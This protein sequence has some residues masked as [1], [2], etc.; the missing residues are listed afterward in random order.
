MP[1]ALSMGGFTAAA[2]LIA[3]PA[4]AAPMDVVA[5]RTAQA[6]AIDGVMDPAWDKAKP[7][8]VAV[9]ENTY[10]PS[11]GYKGITATDVELRALTDGADLFLLV[12]YRD[13]THSI[14]RFPWVKQADGG[15]RK[16]VDKDSTGHENTHY[17]DKVAIFWNI[18][19]KGFAKKGCEQSCHT[20]DN[21]K[22]DG[23]EDSSAGRHFTAGPGERLDMWHMKTAR[24]NP[25][26]QSDDQHVDWSRNDSK[27]WGRKTD[28]KTGGGYVN[29]ETPAKTAPA[30]MPATAGGD[31]YWILDHAKAPL[32][33]SRFKA[34][35]VVGGIVTAPF[36]GPRADVTAKG[37]W[38][39]GVWT[40]EFRRKLVT[41]S[42]TAAEEDVQFSDL[43]K[44][45]PFGVA[46]FDNTQINHLFHKKPLVL[47]FE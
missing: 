12:R 31:V 27:E 23:I 45:Y 19:E 38:A 41:V 1:K 46:V 18:S 34:G 28:T 5:I 21:G 7:T 17:E 42:A 24:T 29:N 9:D 37:V 25:N 30:W 36:H 8:I 3:H 20:A 35:D 6:P 11:N 10:K 22:V 44:A 16:L 2:L 40:F 14:A 4:A 32:D 39:D 26:G 33:D 43:A 13:P 47:R 15:W